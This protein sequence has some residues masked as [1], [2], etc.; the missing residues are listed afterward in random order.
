MMS[1]S[2]RALAE[3]V[4]TATNRIAGLFGL[5]VMRRGSFA[6]MQ[7]AEGR[8]AARS[9][10]LLAVCK[11]IDDVLRRAAV[12]EGHREPASV[13]CAAGP[14]PESQETSLCSELP[15]LLTERL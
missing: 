5:R 15:L 13:G 2:I 7:A 14:H 3:A 12:G 10:A 11:A 1:R 9:D 8:T 6:R 4:A